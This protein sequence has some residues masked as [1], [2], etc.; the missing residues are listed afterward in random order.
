MAR[1]VA[2]CAFCGT[3][4]PPDS[5]A[6]RLTCNERCRRLRSYGKRCSACGVWGYSDPCPACKPPPAWSPSG[7]Q[8]HV[9]RFYLA[10]WTY[11]DIAVALN[12]TTNYVGTTLANL[13]SRGLDIP[14]RRRAYTEANGKP[15]ATDFASKRWRSVLLADPCVYCAAPATDIDHIVPRALGGTDDWTNLAPACDACNSAKNDTTLLAHLARR[16][17]LGQIALLRDA[18]AAWH[19]VGAPI[20]P[21]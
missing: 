3:P 18:A 8:S 7:K 9:L 1:R 16:P 10:G 6:N 14:H 11:A 13:R 5:H 20:S 2:N 19:R 21:A 12:T 15:R 17:L 4:L